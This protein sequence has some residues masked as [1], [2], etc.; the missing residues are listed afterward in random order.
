MVRNG[1]LLNS[2]PIK[3]DPTYPTHLVETSIV[4]AIKS[5]LQLKS[6]ISNLRVNEE[7][8]NQLAFSSFQFLETKH[9]KKKLFSHR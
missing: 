4:E 7:V 2:T 3:D 8:I 5:C 6:L 9:V 1:M